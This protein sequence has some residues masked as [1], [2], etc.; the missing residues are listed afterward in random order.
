M[1]RSVA[2]HHG[3]L[4]LSSLSVQAMCRS[5]AIHHCRLWLSTLSMPAMC[6]SSAINTS[7]PALPQEP[8]CASNVSLS[9]NTSRPFPISYTFRI[10]I[11]IRLHIYRISKR[12]YYGNVFSL[13]NWWWIT[14]KYL[15]VKGQYLNYRRKYSIYFILN[16]KIILKNKNSSVGPCRGTI[17]FRVPHI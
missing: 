3:R 1:C 4:W 13:I 8:D 12:I 16:K 14:I 10:F 7:Q 17:V 5:V 11:Y 2:I 15:Y 6:R 9:S